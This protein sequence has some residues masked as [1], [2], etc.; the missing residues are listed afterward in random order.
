V[1]NRRRDRFET[2]RVPDERIATIELVPALARRLPMHAFVEVDVTEARQ[3]LAADRDRTG[4]TRSF[5]AFVIGCLARAVDEHRGVQAVR[6]GRRVL[7]PRTVDVANLVEVA[8]EGEPVPLP[9]VIRDAAGRSFDELDA[10][11]RGAQH[12]DQL[13]GEFRA[14]ARWLRRVPRPLRWLVWRA[15]ARAP[16]LRTSMGGTVVVTSVGSIVGGRGWGLG[17]VLT[18][19]VSLVVGGIHRAPAL[20]DGELVERDWLCLTISFDHEVVDGAPAARFVRRLVELLED[21]HGLPVP[22]PVPQPASPVA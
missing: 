19:P 8:A 1:A 2:R 22:D 5:T 10:A 21:A 4:Q 9:Q 18:H 15:V 13:V 20:R 11:I 17:G 16:R 6:Q 3:R 12:T 14:R 7:I